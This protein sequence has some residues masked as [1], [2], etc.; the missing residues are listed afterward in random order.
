[1]EVDNRHNE[2]RAD[3]KQQAIAIEAR[4]G[5]LSLEH[6]IH[7][8]T[9]DVLNRAIIGLGDVRAEIERVKWDNMRRTVSKCHSSVSM[10]VHG[11]IL[12][13]KAG[14]ASFILFT[15][16][17]MELRPKP[18]PPPIPQPNFTPKPSMRSMGINID[19]MSPDP[20]REG[21]ENSE[22]VT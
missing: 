13:Y 4:P 18:P 14:L 6:L 22:Y 3:I 21:L 19:E 8:S 15:I 7:R 16:I 10:R 11:L 5:T 2:A 12:L 20:E 1:M 17:F 9:Q